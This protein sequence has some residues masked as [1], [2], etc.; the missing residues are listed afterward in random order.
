MSDTD[1]AVGFR[2]G[3]EVFLAAVYTRWEPLVFTIAPRSLGK[4]AMPT[5]GAR[6]R[7]H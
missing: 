5:V 4:A 7:P 6:R 2:A 3:D 1:V